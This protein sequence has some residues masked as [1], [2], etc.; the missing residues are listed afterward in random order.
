M[1]SMSNIMKSFTISIIFDSNEISQSIHQSMFDQCQKNQIHNDLKFDNSISSLLLKCRNKFDLT[2][3]INVSK[4][5][6]FFKLFI[7]SRQININKFLWSNILNNS[8][9]FTMNFEFLLFEFEIRVYFWRFVI[10]II[11]DFF[12]I[13]RVL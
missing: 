1:K 12:Y 9:S 8:F 11:D 4:F 13:L 2:H 6:H 3:H 7:N 5:W 10:D